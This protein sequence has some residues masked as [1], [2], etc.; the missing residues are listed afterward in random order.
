MILIYSAVL[1]YFETPLKAYS[2]I[3]DIAGGDYEAPITAG[4]TNYGYDKK[5]YF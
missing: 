2:T 5:K 3:H 1:G 4:L